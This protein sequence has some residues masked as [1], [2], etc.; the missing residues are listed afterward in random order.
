LNYR[1][2]QKDT[3][4]KELLGL[5]FRNR[6]GDR[7]ASRRLRFSKTGIHRIL[8]LS[9]ISLFLFFLPLPFIVS[10]I[11]PLSTVPLLKL[12]ASLLAFA[13]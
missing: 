11:V 5:S 2:K 8:L 3:K 6:Q 9:S 12:N 13:P 7:Q 1:F 10:F 4:Q